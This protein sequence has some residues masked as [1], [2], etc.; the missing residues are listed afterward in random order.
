MN[1]KNTV[2]AV[3]VGAMIIFGASVTQA[4]E[5]KST[6]RLRRSS[7]YKQGS[8]RASK[9]RQMYSL[10]TPRRLEVRSERP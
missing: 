9:G 2:E 8:Q 7:I 6:I 10:S 3:V 1:I 5:T 4:A